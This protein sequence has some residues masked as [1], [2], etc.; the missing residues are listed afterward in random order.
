[1]RTLPG[2]T[3]PVAEELQGLPGKVDKKDYL[4]SPYSGLSATVRMYF[5]VISPD[6]K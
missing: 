5:T 2:I 4:F 6:R 1:V 3:H